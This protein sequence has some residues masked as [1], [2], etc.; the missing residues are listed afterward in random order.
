MTIPGPVLD[1][2]TICKDI[3]AKSLMDLEA[4]KL[5]YLTLVYANIITVSYW[6]ILHS[7]SNITFKMIIHIDPGVLIRRV[8][9]SNRSLY[10]R[11]KNGVHPCK[12]SINKARAIGLLIG[13]RF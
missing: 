6:C 1:W 9:M 12:S 3:L 4:C 11:D 7:T 8:Q 10:F 2:S 5:Q 13:C